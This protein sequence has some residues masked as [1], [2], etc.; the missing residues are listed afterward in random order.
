MS[1]IYYI[2]TKTGYK[3]G[4]HIEHI[5]SENDKNRGYFKDVEEFEDQRNLLGGLLLLKGIDNIS[6]SNNSSLKFE[7]K[8]KLF[9]AASQRVLW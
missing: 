7:I 4:Y 8:A 9:Y 2:S 1:G 3:T 5:L 6:S